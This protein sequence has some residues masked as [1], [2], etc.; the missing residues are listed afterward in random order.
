[1]SKTVTV[2][3]VVLERLLD[4]IPAQVATRRAQAQPTPKKPEP[5]TYTQASRVVNAAVE[6]LAQARGLNYPDAFDLLTKTNPKLVI[7]LQVIRT[8]EIQNKGR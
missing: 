2:S 3:R 8:R 1:M 7:G 4:A 5:M 6:R